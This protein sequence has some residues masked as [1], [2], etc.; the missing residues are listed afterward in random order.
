MTLKSSTMLVLLCVGVLVTASYNIAIGAVAASSVV[1][2]TT[3]GFDFNVADRFC[4][5]GECS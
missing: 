5:D 3:G 4:E 2:Q 1:D